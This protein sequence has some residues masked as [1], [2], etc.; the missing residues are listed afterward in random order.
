MSEPASHDR[1]VDFGSQAWALLPVL[2][3]FALVASIWLRYDHPWAENDTVVLT[4]AARAVLHEGTITPSHNA[5]DHGFAF[6]TL[7]ASMAAVTGLSVQAVQL[8]VLP[9]LLLALSL[10]AFIAFR[11]VAGSARTGA[12]AALLLLVQPDFLF[13]SQR[14]SH[15]K[16][17]WTLVLA[18]LYALITSLEG[19]RLRHVAP[20]VITFYLCGFALLSTNA[21]FGSSFT[22]IILLSLVGSVVV[23]RRFF[24]VQ[25]SRRLLPRL[26]YVFLVL[27]ALTYV[28]V[29][30]LYAP[31]ETNLSNLGRVVDRLATLYLNVDTKV[32]SRVESATQ[33]GS[34]AQVSQSR[35]V[36]SPY[37]SVSIGWLSPLTFLLL[38]L[39]TWLMLL[40]T[41]LAWLILAVTFVRRGVARSELPL[42][43]I[44]AFTAAAGLQIALSVASDFAGALGANLQLRLFPVFAVFAIPLV[45][46][47]ASRY[48]VPRRSP[49]VRYATIAI[50]VLVPMFVAVAYPA[51]TLLVA[52]GVAMTLFVVLGWNSSVW[53]RRLAATVGMAAFIYFAAAALLKATNDPIVSNKWTFYSESEAKGLAWANQSLP[54]QFV[55]ADFDER[56]GTASGLEQRDQAATGAF[57]VRNQSAIVRYLFS[58][59]VI[60]DRAVR[61]RQTM[62]EVTS[63][64]LIYTNGSTTIFHRV[65][66][67]PYQP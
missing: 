16:M 17:T 39:F 32:E 49:A 63:N 37:S 47:T 7:I 18:L 46:V 45:V 24:R 14:G 38:T 13:V 15:E 20:L 40:A 28:I 50:G 10:V 1:P 58:S 26:S 67:T 6:P 29:F 48:R 5:Y 42:F 57:W 35:S 30:Y 62:P 36:T 23:T 51:L 55:W 3:A 9:W 44:W 4:S 11:A 21:F 41:V 34:N 53:A 31:A 52:I 56:I 25:T 60:R 8:V 33:Q 59:D 65:P 66:L 22:T 19:R 61:L 2:V 43:L 12:I 27:T 54:D 64:D